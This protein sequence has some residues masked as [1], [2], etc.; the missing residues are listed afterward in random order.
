M[1]SACCSAGYESM[2]AA[3]FLKLLGTRSGGQRI[4]P[5]GASLPLRLHPGEVCHGLREAAPPRP[6][7]FFSP[8]A[9]PMVRRILE[10][11]AGVELD[12]VS[13]SVDEPPLTAERSSAV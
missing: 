4:C 9:S 2:A 12:V 1:R 7:T 10:L 11:P 8:S 13:D 5:Q 3:S 6:E